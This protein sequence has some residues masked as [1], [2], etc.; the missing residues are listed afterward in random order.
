MNPDILKGE[1][2]DLRSLI[3]SVGEVLGFS[4]EEEWTPP[5]LMKEDRTGTYIPRI[6]LVWI[7]RSDERFT[8]LVNES[9]RRMERRLGLQ[10]ERMGVIPK[11]RDP[12]IETVVCFELELSDRSTK[13]LLGDISNLSRMC[14]YGF[15]IVSNVENLAKRACKASMAFSILHGASNVLVLDPEE[16]R[17]ILVGMMDRPRK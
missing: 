6:D 13:Y 17:S 3:K 2:E 12:S 15:L 4:V 16:L 5:P 14:D 11:Y 10:R 1:Q 7:R 8:H 9:L